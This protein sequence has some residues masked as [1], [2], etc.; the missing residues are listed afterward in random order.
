MPPKHE[1]Q[2]TDLRWL[3]AIAAA[4]AAAAAAWVAT[5]RDSLLREA[6]GRQPAP[7]LAVW[8]AAVSG[9]LSVLWALRRARGQS[10]DAAG[11]ELGA[12]AA[13][14]G[15][16]PQEVGVLAAG[17]GRAMASNTCEP[18][19]GGA[20]AGWPS[21]P[22]EVGPDVCDQLGCLRCHGVPQSPIFEALARQGFRREDISARLRP[23]LQAA[24]L[25]RR[26]LSPE[27]GQAPTLLY[28]PRLPARPWWDAA[29]PVLAWMAALEAAADG[30]REEYAALAA[31]RA[32]E[33]QVGTTTGRWGGLYLVNQGVEDAPACA[34]CPATLRAL[35]AAPLMRGC[36]LGS[37][38]FSALA[39]GTRIAPHC[40]G[41]NLRLRCHLALQLPTAGRVAM[42]VGEEWRAW[43]AGRCC[44]FDDSF[45][46]EVSGLFSSV[47]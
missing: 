10:R 18:C 11:S 39:P 20:A 6:G 42:R 41:S 1:P 4:T 33:E 31:S 43:A 3:S 8:L 47:L 25:G 13:A 23:M 24:A 32:A 36:A 35:R 27:A 30:I 22:F 34:A 9:G 28:C 17:G 19:E 46:H 45:E 14:Q 2:Q 40:G 38:F 12:A 7:P 21:E 16:V 44:V 37:A 5:I 29:E 26:L 15:A